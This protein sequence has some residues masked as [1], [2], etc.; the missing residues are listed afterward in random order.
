MSAFGGF[1]KKKN[2]THMPKSEV[3]NGSL[4]DALLPDFEVLKE[5]MDNNCHA[6]TNVSSTPLPNSQRIDIDNESFPDD[7]MAETL[8]NL[9]GQAITEWSK[10][11]GLEN[12]PQDLVL[13]MALVHINKMYKILKK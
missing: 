5:T 11:Y 4:N 8:M 3:N 2:T 13:D 7:D 1:F 9:I 6:K 12:M 10:M